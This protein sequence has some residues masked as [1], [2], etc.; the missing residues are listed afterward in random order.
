[1][2]SNEYMV[3]LKDKLAERRQIVEKLVQEQIYCQICHYPL[4]KQFK[5]GTPRKLKNFTRTSLD[6]IVEKRNGG[7]DDISNL[8]LTHAFCN[9][10]RDFF[11]TWRNQKIWRKNIKEHLWQHEL[12]MDLEK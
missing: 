7:S 4:V 11:L 8:R 9:N 2:T 6:H 5:K 3:S 1:M 12:Y 10:A